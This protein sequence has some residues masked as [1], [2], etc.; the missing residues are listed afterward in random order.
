MRY[1]RLGTATWLIALLLAGFAIAV[2]FVR[3]G[4]SGA[5]EPVREDT[6]VFEWQ[7]LGARVYAA[8]CAS[9][10]PA[11]RGGAGLPPLR[12]H[13]VDLFLSEGG[14]EYLIDLLLDGVV[15]SEVDGAIEL[16]ES[17]PPFDGQTDAQ[18]AAVLNHMLT[19]WGNDGHLP[20]DRALYLPEDVKTRRGSEGS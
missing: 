18:L 8:E 6:G 7:D 3:S 13:A 19:S 15:R 11:G 4:T 9:C 5:P 2:A 20:P 12:V 1:T 17:H 10:H 16:M 14:R